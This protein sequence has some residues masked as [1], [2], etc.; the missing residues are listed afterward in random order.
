MM[1]RKRI[2]FFVNDFGLTGSETLL[3]QF[4]SDLSKD[5]RYQIF[6]VTTGK[7]SK[8]ELELTNDIVFKSFN[9]DFS[10]VEKVLFKVGVNVFKYKLKKL[11]SGLSP[12]IAYLNT[13]N[14]AYLIPYISQFN[15]VNILHVHELLM[16]LN[17]LDKKSFSNMIHLTDELV[18]CSD[19]VT[20]LY[21]DI[22]TKKIT[23][24]NSIPS[25][26]N[27]DSNGPLENDYEAD[28]QKYKIA[29]AGT[30]CYRKGFD[31]FLEIA[32]RLDSEKFTMY[33]F[34]K[35]DE[36]AYSEWVKLK[37]QLPKFQHVVIISLPS[38]IAY[39]HALSKCDL[40]L[41]TSRE[42]SMGMV[43][44]DAM[45]ANLPII[46]LEENGSKLILDKGKGQLIGTN[47]IVNIHNIVLD[48]IESKSEKTKNSVTENHYQVEFAKFAQLFEKY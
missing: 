3:S 48:S 36:S 46:S 33:W 37:L 16:G 30:I 4:I 14:N 45:H 21:E 11:F 42:E 31:R 2:Y 15:L 25:F 1:R 32:E 29:C 26:K 8:S 43:L 9:K 23:Q 27:F 38:Q 41:F 22:Y 7:N 13:V 17:S 18:T 47:D 19:L 5:K 10:F 20:N 35:F 28:S 44:F 6:V 34:G 40:F 39:L 12:D 24:I